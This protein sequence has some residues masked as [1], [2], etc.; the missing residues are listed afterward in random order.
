[1]APRR[2]PG[3]LCS[4]RLGGCSVRAALGS[5]WQVAPRRAGPSPLPIIAHPCGRP[6]LCSGPSPGHWGH[7]GS[8]HWIGRSFSSKSKTSKPQK[9]LRSCVWGRCCGR[10][11][12]GPCQP[13]PANASH[14]ASH[15]ASDQHTATRKP[16]EAAL[17][18]S[19]CPSQLWL[20]LPFEGQIRSLSFLFPL[21]Y[22]FAFQTYQLKREF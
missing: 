15:A 6:G 8:G 12:S 4:P 7:L 10:V 18:L 16:Q 19:C 20:S 3:V 2:P 11:S 1:M 13:V 9:T 22:H 14:S 21:S 5:G 17:A